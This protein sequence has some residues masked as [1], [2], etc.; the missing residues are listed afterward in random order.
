M[1]WGGVGGGA[2]KGERKALSTRSDEVLF[3]G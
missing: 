2:S 1:G 3:V